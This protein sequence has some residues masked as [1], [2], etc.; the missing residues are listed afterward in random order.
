MAELSGI[1]PLFCQGELPSYVNSSLYLAATCATSSSGVFASLPLFVPDSSGYNSLNTSLYL[2]ISGSPVP[3]SGTLSLYAEGASRHWMG[4]L[5]LFAANSGVTTSLNLYASGQGTTPGALPYSGVLPLF[6]Q[7]ADA[8]SLNLFC[9]GPAYSASGSLN[10][11]ANA[12]ALVSGSLNLVVPSS[13]GI[14][15][16]SIHLSA[17]GI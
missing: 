10:L 4:S 13:M 7:R 12:N 3:V 8:F 6:L 11:Y 14:E 17:G 9:Q 1:L 5:D 2:W 15:L 16:T